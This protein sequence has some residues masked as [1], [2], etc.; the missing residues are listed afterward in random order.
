MRCSGLGPQD[1][2]FQKNILAQ[3]HIVCTDMQLVVHILPISQ[4][5]GLM[6]QCF[7]SPNRDISSPTDIWFGDVQ[8]KSP[9]KWTFTNKI[10]IKGH[11]SQPLDR[12]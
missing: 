5:L 6:S 11:Q 10:P 12:F 8:N 3:T 1:A 4:G 9:K 7:T 2:M